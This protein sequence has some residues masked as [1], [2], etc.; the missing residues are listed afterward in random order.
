MAVNRRE[1]CTLN[2]ANDARKRLRLVVPDCYGPAPSM[3]RLARTRRVSSLI[4]ALV[5]L[6]L[7]TALPLSSADA[8]PSSSK[9]GK[10]SK[11][12]KGGSMDDTAGSDIQSDG[13]APGSK[14][15]AAATPEPEPTQIPKKPKPEPIV[16]EET[17]EPEP[18]EPEPTG[19]ESVRKN[20]FSF[21]VQKDVLSFGSQKGVCP[22]A[23]E[24]GNLSAG[25]AHY[26]CRDVTGVYEGRV[27][28]L[29]GNEIKGGLALATT[30]VL[31]GYDRLLIERL[32]L[33]V[34]VGYIFGLAP[35][36]RDVK[37]AFP[38]H[39]ELRSALFFGAAPF[40][41]KSLR[42][43]VTLGVGVGEIDGHVSVEYYENNIQYQQNKI[44]RLDVWRRTG[45]G[46]GAGG[47]GLQYP[48]GPFAVNAEVRALLML[49]D[50]GVGMAGALGLAYGF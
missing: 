40:E 23:D 15:S 10:K 24:F 42:P 31:V 2:G 47:L 35:S 36:V 43:Y 16:L 13:L 1:M 37:R 50:P 18:K 46:F 20:W 38:W 30:R 21:S 44:G 33:G 14:D 17:P 11:K 19:P 22:A 27:Y 48:I 25:A 49:G 32:T 7:G 28:S 26:S 45:I 29:A 4:A 6:T 8:K 34:R 41:T 5:A 12:K 3:L 39:F 9:K